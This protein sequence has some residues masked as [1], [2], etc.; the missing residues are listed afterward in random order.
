MR[1]KMECHY[2][3]P[4]LLVS[5]LCCITNKLLAWIK[6]HSSRKWTS[7][8]SHLH[9]CRF[10][11]SSILPITLIMKMFYLFW[12][13]DRD[14]SWDIIHQSHPN[15]LPPPRVTWKVAP[16]FSGW[17]VFVAQEFVMT[18][19]PI[20]HHLVASSSAD[21]FHPHQS[22]KDVLNIFAKFVE[23]E[24]K[25]LIREGPRLCWFLVVML[26]NVFTTSFAHKVK[27]LLRDWYG[28]YIYQ[29]HLFL[30]FVILCYVL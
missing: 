11:I 27:N 26:W 30:K 21:D 24:K 28:K 7:S 29:I 15:A 8:Q 6:R 18:L 1:V 14:C 17:A 10:I 5:V 12:L 23:F 4:F 19:E 25:S 2:N 16:T 9:F 20:E 13:L 22:L 3:V